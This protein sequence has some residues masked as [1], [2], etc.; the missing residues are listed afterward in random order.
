MTGRK[1]LSEFYG[2]LGKESGCKL[3]KNIAELRKKRNV[4]HRARLVRITQTLQ[5]CRC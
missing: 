5:D 3:E 4:A 1:S 2:V